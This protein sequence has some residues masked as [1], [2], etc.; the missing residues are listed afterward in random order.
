[1]GAA[2]SRSLPF[3]FFDRASRRGWFSQRKNRS[4]MQERAALAFFSQTDTDCHS[5]AGFAN[6]MWEKGLELT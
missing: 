1:M 4:K 3:V 2:S 5:E 6:T